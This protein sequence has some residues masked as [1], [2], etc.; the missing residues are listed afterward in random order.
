MGDLLIPVSNI[1]AKLGGSYSIATY[2]SRRFE[3]AYPTPGI[4][5]PH[6]ASLNNWLILVEKIV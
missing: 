5:L 6:P 3:V 1:D 2:S 4:D